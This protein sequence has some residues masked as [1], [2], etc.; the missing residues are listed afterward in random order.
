M[1]LSVIFPRWFHGGPAAEWGRLKTR[2]AQATNVRMNKRRGYNGKLTDFL[3]HELTYRCLLSTYG[4]NSVKITGAESP[5]SIL[6]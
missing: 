3:P 5:R 6:I 4:P 1:G 2:T